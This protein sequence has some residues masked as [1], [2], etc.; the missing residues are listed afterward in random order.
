MLCFA[1]CYAPPTA[2]YC[3]E[4]IQK[5]AMSAQGTRTGYRHRGAYHDKE[6]EIEPWG[7]RKKKNLRLWSISMLRQIHIKKKKVSH[8]KR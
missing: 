2:I 3:I 4:C 7:R 8:A 5:M 6:D 1:Y